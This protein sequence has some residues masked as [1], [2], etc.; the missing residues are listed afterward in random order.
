MI[1]GF[2]ILECCRYKEITAAEDQREKKQS[3]HAFLK[4]LDSSLINYSA[5]FEGTGKQI[6]SKV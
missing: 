2:K 4:Q 3:R 6:Y 1:K 5:A